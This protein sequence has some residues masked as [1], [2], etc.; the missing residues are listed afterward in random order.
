RHKVLP[1]DDRVGERINPDTAGRPVM[2]RGTSQ[3]LLAGMGHLPEN[4]ALPLKNKSH[5][6]TAEVVVP[7]GGAEGVIVAQGSNI[8]GWS[9]Y[10][11]D[12]GVKDWHNLIR[13]Q[14]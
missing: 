1:L 9:L 11:K 13:G 12:G 14:H 2:V 7:E 4:C 8:G 6:V 5:S 10:A 3:L